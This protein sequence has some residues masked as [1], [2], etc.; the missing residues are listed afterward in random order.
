MHGR[1]PLHDSIAVG[2]G[3]L[4]QIISGNADKEIA[5]LEMCTQLR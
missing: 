1:M 4:S 5:E 3:A 2:Y